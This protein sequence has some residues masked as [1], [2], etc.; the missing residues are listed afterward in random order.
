MTDTGKGVGVYHSTDG[1]EWAAN[2][3]I[4]DQFGQRTDDG[5]Y[6]QHPDVVILDNRAYMFYFVHAGRCLFDNP[7]F[8]KSYSSTAP[9]E[10]KRSSLQIAELEIVD[11]KLVC[12]RDKFLKNK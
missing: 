5:W 8:T 11:G 1:N 3:T 9:F 7:S 6:G 2:G 12:K 4:M 10:W